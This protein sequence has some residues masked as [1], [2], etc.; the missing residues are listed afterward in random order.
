MANN[1]VDWKLHVCALCQVYDGNALIRPKDSGI[2][3]M[4]N[5]LDRWKNEFERFP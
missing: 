3:T 1:N 5:N 2:C 4:V